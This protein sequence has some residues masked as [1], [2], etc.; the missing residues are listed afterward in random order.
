MSIVFSYPSRDVFDVCQ[1]VP[2]SEKEFGVQCHI[3]KE[4]KSPKEYTTQHVSV[5]KTITSGKPNKDVVF[6]HVSLPGKTFDVF[7]NEKFKIVIPLRAYFKLLEFFK[8]DFDAT[9][10]RM[11]EEATGLMKQKEWILIEPGLS[12]R[13]LADIVATLELDSGSSYTLSLIITRRLDIHKTTIVLAYSNET[14]GLL[15][16]PHNAFLQMMKQ[17]P[18]VATY[19]NYKEAVPA[20]KS[21]QS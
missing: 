2:S 11:E 18:K 21:R 3:L 6:M 9:I 8:N 14:M 20:K 15:S 5:V 17:I 10:K 1:F 19:C 13:G 16:L 12:Y 7:D 4:T